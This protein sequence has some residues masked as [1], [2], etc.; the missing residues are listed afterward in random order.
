MSLVERVAD[1]IHAEMEKK[2]YAAGK[3][4][5]R[6]E[7]HDELAQAMLGALGFVTCQT[8]D[9]GG[10]VQY[11]QTDIIPCPDCAGGVVPSDEMIERVA[12][13]EHDQWVHWSQAVA[14]TWP[15]PAHWPE[16]WVPYDE[17]TEKA[18]EKDREWARAALLAAIGEDE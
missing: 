15:T 2:G 14:E 4:E 1:V 17:L 8:C 7:W 16:L 18:K 10:E 9:G 12:A 11:R 5:L 13:I 3:Y 6:S